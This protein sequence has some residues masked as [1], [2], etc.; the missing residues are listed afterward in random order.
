MIPHQRVLYFLVV[1]PADVWADYWG[2][3]FPSTERCIA[4]QLRPLPRFEEDGVEYVP[5]DSNLQDSTPKKL[6]WGK[7]R[8]REGGPTLRETIDRADVRLFFGPRPGDRY[9]V[10][11]PEI[12]EHVLRHDVY[13]LLN[14]GDLNAEVD[15]DEGAAKERWKTEDA[16]IRRRVPAS[17]VEATDVVH[18]PPV[19]PHRFAGER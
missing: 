17:Q 9:R 19:R 2:E 12:S 1:M 10:L 16:V 13:R 18:G 6:R 14:G 7:M 11:P 15:G 8:G 4:G 5:A 3:A